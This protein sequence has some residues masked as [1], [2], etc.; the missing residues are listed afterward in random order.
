MIIRHNMAAMNANQ[1]LNVT[2]R[3]QSKVTEKLASGFRINRAAD[4]ASGLSISEKMRAKIR[5][6]DQA[7]QNAQDGISLIQVAEGALGEVQTCLQRVNELLVK[8]S[9]GTYLD[10]DRQKVQDEIDNLLKEVDHIADSTKFNNIKL[11]DG[12]SSGTGVSQSDKQKFIN[13]LNG[14]WLNDAAKKIESTTG[15]K[16]D[17]STKLT[18]NFK[19]INGDA[20]ANMSGWYLGND[21]NLNINTKYMNA[22]LAYNGE[23]G[24]TLG[25]IP[26]DRLITHEMVHGFMFNNVSST[27]KPASWFVEGLAEGVHGASDIRYQAYEHGPSTDFS[28]INAELQSF[29]FMHSDGKDENYTI[30]YIATSYL[31]KA[32]ET[33]KTGSFKTMMGEMDQTDETFEELVVNY[34]SATDYASFISSMKDDASKAS[35]FATDFL[36]AKC[37]INITDGKADPLDGYDTSSSDVIPNSGSEVAPTDK[38]TTLKLGSTDVTVN[39]EG[40]SSSTSTGGIVLQLGDTVE[41]T[42]SI[43]IESVKTADLGIENLSAKTKE[44][45]GKSI[46][47]CKDAINTVSEMRGSL[48]AYQNRLEYA[49]NNLSTIQENTQSAESRIR[50]TDMA[51]EMMHYMRN[52]VLTQSSQFLLVQANQNPNQ[53]LQLLQ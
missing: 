26:T 52:N 14:S 22:G 44:D 24:P 20:V 4:D 25:G 10:N 53:V 46:E 11:L 2:A 9:N 23:D 6:L 1:K 31:Y 15:W 19:N 17:P 12:S 16:L 47:I 8:S 29:D 40:S 43:G 49:M 13:W 34:T 32:V 42:M 50:D 21:L 3:N 28:K 41:Q 30:G 7:Q 45:A 27:A 33:Y 5:G 51:K 35:N 37:G 48:G 38:T 39:W 36:E 18:V